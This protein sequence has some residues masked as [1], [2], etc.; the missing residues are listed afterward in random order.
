MGRVKE[1][2]MEREEGLMHSFDE[3]KNVCAEHFNDPYLQAYINDMGHLGKCSYCGKRSGK[4]LS[5][6]QF[7]DFINSKLSQ[8]LCPLDDANLPSA[9]SWYDDDDEEIP[10]VSR[11]GCYAIPDNAERYESVPDLMDNYGLY[12]SDE[13]LNEDI[14]SCFNYDEFTRNDVLKKTW[15]KNYPMHGIILSKW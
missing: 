8:R 14:A 12:T 13:S 4:V 2:M 15:M 9:S 6:S 11:I 1:M 3:D 5:M 7:M 10:G